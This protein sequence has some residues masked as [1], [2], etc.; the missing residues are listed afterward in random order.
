MLL[1]L[2][3]AVAHAADFVDLITFDGSYD[4]KLVNDPVMGGVSNS[5]WTVDKKE[6]MATWVGDCRIVPS[7]QAPGFCNAET[8]DP[9]TSSFGDASG[10]TH[11]DILLRSR[12]DYGGFKISFAANTI[13]P[14]F[15]CFKSDFEVNSN[16][17]WQIVSIPFSSFSNEWSPST[18][19]PTTKC[20]EDSRVCPTDSDLKKIEQ[21]GFWME[22]VEGHFD[23]D[24]KWVRA[25]YGKSV[26]GP[27]AYT[28]NG[29]IQDNLRWGM[30]SKNFT[31]DGDE[32]LTE[33]ICCDSNYAGYAEPAGLF[34]QLGLFDTLN[35]NGINT[36]YDPV[37]GKP[38]FAAPQ[39]R[40][41]EEWKAESV[42]HGWP[43]FRDAEVVPDAIEIRENVVYSKVGG[44]RLGDNL[45][46]DSGNRYCL[47]MCCLNGQPKK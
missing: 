19:E 13:N 2:C 37:S 11:L 22:G 3:A 39:G 33:A 25:S 23:V 46:D 17:G 44:T 12:V 8:S 21:F 5:T 14:Q 20:S 28:C 30:S 41:F 42:E 24:I 7:L 38:L 31:F 34:T 45:P 1:L 4:W 6:G 18:G 47:D 16:G 29:P 35:P 10:F 27:E 40:T 26:K 32:L 36:F 43:S 15:K 9:F